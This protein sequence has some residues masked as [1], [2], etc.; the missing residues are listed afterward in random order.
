MAQ[1]ARPLTRRCAVEEL[2]GA[3]RGYPS[4]VLR[5]GV[6][7]TVVMAEAIRWL[8]RQDTL[9]AGYA[10]VTSLPDI[11]EVRMPP[12]SEPCY[13]SAGPDAEGSSEACVSNPSMAVYE[14]W[15]IATVRLILERLAARQVAIFYQTDGRTSGEG[16]AWLSKSILCH[17]GAR[18]AG[19]SC[20]WHKIVC[21][22]APGVPRTSARVGYT[23]LLCFSR[24]W[25]EPPG[26][27]AV[28][29]L[30]TRGHMSW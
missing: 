20:V 13:D 1:A 7:R 4:G 27:P 26:R 29:V 25:R 10:V 8:Q 11:S 9:P 24:E 19:A 30:P 22:T 23:H 28:D 15:F 16:G 21:S 5:R 12:R 2:D 14:E 3:L 6:G 18:A 17:M